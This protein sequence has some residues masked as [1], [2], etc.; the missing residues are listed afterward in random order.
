MPPPPNQESPF[1]S[2]DGHASLK[3]KP[4]IA[5]ISSRTPQATAPSN[6]STLES[7]Q[8]R[9]SPNGPPVDRPGAVAP[10]RRMRGEAL[11][12]LSGTQFEEMI[13]CALRDVRVKLMKLFA[14]PFA[15]PRVTKKKLRI[16]PYSPDFA[17]RSE[18]GTPW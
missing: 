9:S 17:L 5:A 7:G 2:K 12:Y 3:T 13:F 18:H 15:V 11:T 6:G 14:A 1:A 16:P 10:G 8:L 4:I